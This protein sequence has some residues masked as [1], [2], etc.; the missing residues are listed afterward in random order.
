M[1]SP[2]PCLWN[3]ASTTRIVSGIVSVSRTS[4]SRKISVIAKRSFTQTRC[5]SGSDDSGAR[6]DQFIQCGEYQVILLNSVKETGRDAQQPGPRVHDD[7]ALAQ[8]AHQ[9]LGPLQLQ[10]N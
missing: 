7:P 1:T 5:G 10:Q 8:R 3:M 2:A 9:F 6:G 4:S